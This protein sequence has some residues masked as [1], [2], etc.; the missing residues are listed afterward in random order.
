MKLELGDGVKIVV[1]GFDCSFWGTVTRVGT[2]HVSV[3]RDS[4]PFPI[5]EDID[6]QHIIAITRR[7]NSNECI[8]IK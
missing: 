8:K 4:M 5:S 2:D 7:R 1:K 6:L 3:K